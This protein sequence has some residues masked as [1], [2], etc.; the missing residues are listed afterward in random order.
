M[1]TNHDK[2]TLRELHI[3]KCGLIY[4]LGN[5]C[6]DQGIKSAK[7]INWRRVSKFATDV[8]NECQER[9]KIA[10][11]KLNQSPNKN[12]REFQA[13]KIGNENYQTDLAASFS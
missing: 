1:I 8:V 9:I 12:D 5:I 13:I 4:S 11:R 2:K 10:A 6:K 7:R 3:A